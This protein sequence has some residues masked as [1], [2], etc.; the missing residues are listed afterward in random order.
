MKLN[1]CSIV[2]GKFRNNNTIIA[3]NRDRNYIPEIKIVRTMLDDV[4]IC[5]FEDI[6]TG[7]IEGMNEHGIGVVNSSLLVHHD[8]KEGHIVKKTKKKTKDR[9]KVMVALSFRDI[10]SCLKHLKNFDGG[11]TGHTFVADKNK[12]YHIEHVKNS[13]AKIIKLDNHPH[14]QTNHGFSFENV[15]YTPKQGLRYSS[16]KIRQY[17]IIK[18]LL[19]GTQYKTTYDVLNDMTDFNSSSEPMLNPVRITGDMNTTSQIA[20]NLEKLIFYFRGVKNYHIF[21]GVKNN[22]IQGHNPKIRIKILKELETY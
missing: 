6:I 11:L 3:K 10:K 21:D 15:G 16:S 13:P 2:I 14:V 17:K 18:K 1:E 4:E 5:Y 22:L 20:M 12:S 19:Q 8:E 7:W 9:P